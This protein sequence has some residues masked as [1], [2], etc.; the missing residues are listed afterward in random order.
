MVHVSHLQL[1]VSRN[2]NHHLVVV[3][4]V[5]TVDRGVG[6]KLVVI[7]PGVKQSATGDL[8]Q[9]GTGQV[10]HEVVLAHPGVYIVLYS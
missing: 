5:T 4:L 10:H 9:H 2:H 8:V 3:D 1:G 7:A 6:Q